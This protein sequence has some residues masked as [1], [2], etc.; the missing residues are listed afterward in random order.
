VYAAEWETH[1]EMLPAAEQ[2]TP[3]FAGSSQ[4]NGVFSYPNIGSIVMC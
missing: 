2:L 1:P 3:L 4:G